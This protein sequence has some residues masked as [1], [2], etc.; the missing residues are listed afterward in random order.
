MAVKAYNTKVDTD[1]EFLSLAQSQIC[2]KT[3]T[4]AVV[5]THSHTDTVIH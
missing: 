1:V 2:N 4:H 5:V 3:G